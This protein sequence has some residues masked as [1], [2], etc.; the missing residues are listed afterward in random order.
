MPDAQTGEDAGLQSLRR[1]GSVMERTARGAGWIIL[2]RFSTR[3]IGLISTLILARLLSPTDF[4]VVALAMTFTQGL[5]A[6]AELGT[7][8]AIIRAD[9]PDRALYDTGFTINALRG[10][11]VAI[12]LVLIAYPAAAFFHNPHLAPVVM[13]AAIVSVLGG[14]ENIG[15]VDFRRFIVFEQEFK[16]KIVPRLLELV[17]VLSLGFMLRNYWA[18][19]FAILVSQTST[20]ALTYYMHPYR[21]RLTLSAW[22]RM[23]SYSTLFWLTS[24][25]GLL[26]GLSTQT[27]IGRIAGVGA[28]GVFGVGG[29]IA[30]L[31][32]SE[33][34]GPLCRAAFSGFAEIRKSDD[35]GAAMLVRMVGLLAML[36]FPAGVGLSLVADPV[37]RLGFGPQW[38]GAI[39]VLEILGIFSGFA[40]FA[41]VSQT[42]F[43]VQAWMKAGLKVSVGLTIIQ[44]TLL[45]ALVP[46]FGLLGAA[47]AGAATGSIGQ[48]I[49]F[50]TTIRRLR[51]SPMEIVRR[52]WR[53]LVGCVVMAVVLVHLGLGWSNWSGSPASL[54]E[55]LAV[56]VVLGAAI[57]GASVLL[58][59]LWSGRP[60]GPERDFIRQL[61]RIR[62]Q[63]PDNHRRR[64]AGL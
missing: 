31:P 2:W 30:A 34:I 28:V 64:A 22:N 57:Y 23:A 60:D 59:W 3:G 10:I 5:Q 19:M 9:M 33:V 50:G 20:T 58:L 17:T 52:L 51:I 44:V 35:V 54:G 56:A 13:I 43:A 26:R 12:V 42:V 4:G 53:S 55:R 7:E 62:R 46:R 37:V 39:P 21:P 41:M 18:L 8:N 29:E 40:T 61:R 16:L 24:I 45:L 27:V 63:A 25:V 14:I 47:V 48:G 49:L 38:T 6:L 36:M 15:V 11:G 32:N 1:P